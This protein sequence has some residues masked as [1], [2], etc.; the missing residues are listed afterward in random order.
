MSAAIVN[1]A[2]NGYPLYAGSQPGANTEASVRVVHQ[3][4]NPL[5]RAFFSRQNVGRIQATLRDTIR[6]KTGFTIDRQSSDDIAVIMQNQ[7]LLWAGNL[8]GANDVIAQVNFM[9]QKVLEILLPMVAS[10]VKQYMAYLRDASTLPTPIDRP[11]NVS[12]AGSKTLSMFQ[13]I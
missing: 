1:T 4:A 7:Y 8:Q 6:A 10:G 3:E 11:E 9:N 2:V 12:I 13:G 5:N